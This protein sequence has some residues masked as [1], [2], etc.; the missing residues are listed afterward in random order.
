MNKLT[1][2]SAWNSKGGFS[3]PKS[4]QG[5]LNG[6]T[7]FIAGASCGSSCGAGGGDKPKPSKS[8][9]CGASDDK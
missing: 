5:Y 9:A 8:S 4:A 1:K 3:S 6:G 2:L 7:G